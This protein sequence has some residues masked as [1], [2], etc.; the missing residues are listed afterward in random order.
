MLKKLKEFTGFKHE[1]FIE[2]KGNFTAEEIIWQ[3]QMWRE[4]LLI[5]EKKLPEITAFMERCNNTPGLRVC[6]TGA[7]SSGYCADMLAAAANMYLGYKA[8]SPHTTDIVGSP[9]SVLFKDV[10]TL[11]ISLGRSGNS[12][13]SVGA[14]EYARKKI[15]PPSNLFEICVTCAKNGALCKIS[16]E[17]EN[18]MQIIL[19]EKTCDRGFAMTSSFT[20]MAVAG[21]GVLAYKNFPEFKENILNLASVVSEHFN[22][23]CRTAYK[24]VTEKSFDR[25][26]FLGAGVLKGIAHESFVKMSELTAGGVNVLWETPMGFRHGPK[27]MITDDTYI[28]HMVSGDSHTRKYDIDLLRELCAQKKKY[29][30]IA[31]SGMP[32]DIEGISE[33]VDYG[34]IFNTD[35]ANDFYFALAGVVFSQVFAFYK[36]QSM[37]I[38]SD[39]PCPGGEVNRV[40]QGVT[41]Y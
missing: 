31:L 27:S 24:A 21:Y 30:I 4:T 13:E 16:E 29:K 5:L 23:L 39:N 10:P 17:S 40:V 14:V 15:T 35:F 6:I 8:D 26:A 33:C 7:G 34:F 2:T 25:A 37:G 3:P 20:S 11:L 18:I 32:L 9:D 19:P 1:D 28:V 38:T 41:I 22:D 36:S 12:P